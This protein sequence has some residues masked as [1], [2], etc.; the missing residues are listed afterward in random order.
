MDKWYV[1]VNPASGYGQGLKRFEAIQ[2]ELSAAHIEYEKVFTTAESK[3]D[4]KV[5]AAIRLGYRKFICVGGDG[6]LQDMANGIL[7]QQEIDS[8][9]LTICMVSTGTGNDWI[10]TPKVSKNAA[11]AI[12]LIQKGKTI[13]QNVG[14]INYT[15]NGE[16]MVRY[17]I[18]FAGVGF[19][20]YV[21][22]QTKS[23]K[24]IGALGYLLGMAVCLF[25]YRQ[26]MV[27]ITI[28]GKDYIQPI[29]MAM[30]GI[31]SY[32]GGGMYLM[33][34][35]SL[36][37][38]NFSIVIIGNIPVWKVLFNIMKLYNGKLDELREVSYFSSA[39]L[40]IENMDKEIPL[41]LE[42]DGE[43]IGEGPFSITLLKNQINIL[44]P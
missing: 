40:Q 4:E 35:A 17:F 31:G 38:E 7:T 42:A 20:A 12:A 21:V 11:E 29:Y 25:R 30:A 18:N 44:V 33:P 10:K 19:D 34:K 15:A 14:K 5:K 16:D 27:K 39:S 41:L 24:K 8:K 43:E 22:N 28:D 6:H 32:G 37:G 23:Y 2:K 9:E 13:C 1:I 3:A 26:P 36:T